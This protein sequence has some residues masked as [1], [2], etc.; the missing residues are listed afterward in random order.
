[1]KNILDNILA[2]FGISLLAVAL[3]CLDINFFVILSLNSHQ[4]YNFLNPKATM[5]LSCTNIDPFHSPTKSSWQ[6]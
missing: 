2:E 6:D 1:M 3:L 5:V 4:L